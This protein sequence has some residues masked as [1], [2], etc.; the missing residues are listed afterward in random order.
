MN[1]SPVGLAAY[2]LEKFSTATNFLYISRED[3]GLL[4]KFTYDELLDNV[5]LYWITK[6]ATSSFRIYAESFNKKQLSLG[7]DKYVRDPKVDSRK[8]HLQISAYQ[9]TPKYPAPLPG[10]PMKYSILQIGCWEKNLLIWC[11]LVILTKVD[12]LQ[13][14]KCPSYWPRTCL[15]PCGRWERN[16][17]TFR[18]VL[19]EINKDVKHKRFD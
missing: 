14:W 8:L 6:S 17:L 11:T 19:Y 18:I 3:A 16:V 13:L 1:D 9:S 12:I 2:I 5:M 7:M 10:F 15:R 4:E